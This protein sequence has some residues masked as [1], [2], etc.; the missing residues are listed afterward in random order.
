MK[1]EVGNKLL[2]EYKI[3]K[4]PSLLFFK[5]GEIIGKIEGYYGNEEKEILLKKIAKIT[6]PSSR[7]KKTPVNL[8][9]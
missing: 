8:K 2:K 6:K 5:A 9:K 7:K 3:K 1:V 4:L